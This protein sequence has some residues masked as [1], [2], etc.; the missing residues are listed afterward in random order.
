MLLSAFAL[1]VQVIQLV[2]LAKRW[3]GENFCDFAVVRNGV[4]S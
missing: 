2:M 4:L 1:S 3:G